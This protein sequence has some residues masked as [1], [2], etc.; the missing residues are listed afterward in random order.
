M[1][2]GITNPDKAEL[3]AREFL[4]RSQGDLKLI[5]PNHI[6]PRVGFNGHNP[7]LIPMFK[8]RPKALIHPFPLVLE[9]MNAVLRWHLIHRT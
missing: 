1:H 3:F 5:L 7:P 9:S 2:R 6:L 4:D 8:P